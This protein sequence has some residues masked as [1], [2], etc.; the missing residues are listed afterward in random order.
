MGTRENCQKTFHFF[1]SIKNNLAVVII[2]SEMALREFFY[3][4]LHSLQPLCRVKLT[5][6]LLDV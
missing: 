6:V 4:A 5:G 3:Y 2:L 1:L